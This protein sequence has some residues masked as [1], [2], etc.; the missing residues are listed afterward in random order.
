MEAD[1]I[2]NMLQTNDRWLLRGIVA[3][4]MRQT[5][6]EQVFQC[7][8]ELNGVGF[9]SVDAPFLS[10][11]ALQLQEHGS[12]SPKQK[13]WA[14]KKMLKYAGQLARIAKGEI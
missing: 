12:L 4:W 11:L 1:I 13:E 6:R 10:S 9:N 5:S 7:T 2:R 8:T 3:I 14:R